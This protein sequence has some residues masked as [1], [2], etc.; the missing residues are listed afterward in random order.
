VRFTTWTLDYHRADWLSVLALQRH[1]DKATVDAEW[2]GSHKL[3]I[4][5]TNVQAL[6]I[7]LP[8]TLPVP[9]NVN[10]S[11]D[12]ESFEVPTRIPSDKFTR[13]RTFRR[14]DSHWVAT[15]ADPP[16]RAATPSKQPGMQGPIDDAFTRGFIVVKSTKP[17]LNTGVGA[18][19]NAELTR[20]TNEWR[21]QFRGDVRVIEASEDEVTRAA[22]SGQ[23]LILW[24]DPASNPT[25]ANLLPKF[26]IQWDAKELRLGTNR[27]DAATHVPVLIFPNPLNPSRYIVLNSGPTF[28]DFGAASN[29]QQ[30]PKLPDYAVLDITVPRS[31]RLTRG[32]ALA[33]FFD[34]NWGVSAASGPR[35]Q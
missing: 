29:A 12:G 25:L 28:L 31:E 4:A 6:Q 33:G 30:T 13:P 19:L 7:D 5:T 35:S 9:D 1:W 23:N 16:S 32:V 26:P 18:W 8:E 34:E 15:F 10:I 24:G 11:L 20:F 14:I 27:F 22:K 3:R 21:A 17:A 2:T